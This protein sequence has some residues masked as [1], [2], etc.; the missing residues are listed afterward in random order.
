MSVRYR[1][2]PKASDLD[3]VARMLALTGVFTER[4]IVVAKELIEDRI[5]HGGQSEYH[6]VFAEADG[7]LAGYVC[8]GPITITEDRYDLYWI[9]TDPGHER[10]GIARGLMAE[11]ERIMRGEGCAIVYVDT[12]SRDVY[13]KARGF[14]ASCGYEV[15]ATVRDYFADRDS[16]VIYAKR[17]G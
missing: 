9:A 4:E 6:F 14:Y 11:A 12:S 16:K 5:N 8:Y 2:E 13:D 17:L 15:A 3:A 1:F 7:A 10:R